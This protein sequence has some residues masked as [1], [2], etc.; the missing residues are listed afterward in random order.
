MKIYSIILALLSAALFGIATPASKFLL[1][2]FSTFQ[3]AG[4]LYLGGVIGVIPLMIYEN[5]QSKVNSIDKLNKNNIFRLLGA[6]LF[7]GILGPVFLLLGLN[8]ASASSVSIWLNLEMP[9]TAILGYFLFRD[10]LEN[11]QWEFIRSLA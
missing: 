4:I 9:A 2:S 8:L 6:I 11:N 1:E 10:H 7:G 5:T 3:L